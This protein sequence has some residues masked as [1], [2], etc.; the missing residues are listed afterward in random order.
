[1]LHISIVGIN[2]VQRLTMKSSS[3]PVFIYSSNIAIQSL[4]FSKQDFTTN[5][6]LFFLFSYLKNML[7]VKRTCQRSIHVSTVN[8]VVDT[9]RILSVIRLS[10]KSHVIT[11]W[12]L[13][14]VPCDVYVFIYFLFSSFCHFPFNRK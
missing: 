1:M 8:R 6:V 14:M 10:Q 4:R 2:H 9:S 13:I 11:V 12:F 3:S 5:K 7:S